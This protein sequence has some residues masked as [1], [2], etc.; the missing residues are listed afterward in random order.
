MNQRKQI[1]AKVIEILTRKKDDQFQTMAE[2]RV[3]SRMIGKGDESECP[4][5]NV[6]LK[7]EDLEKFDE[8]PRT[9]KRTAK[10]LIECVVSKKHDDENL[11]DKADDF[12]TQVETILNEN[13]FLD[14]TV[15][16][17]DEIG[18]EADT[19]Q[20]GEEPI[21]GILLTYDVVYYSNEFVIPDMGDF[22][23]IDQKFQIDENI[24]ESETTLPID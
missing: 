3:H 19:T 12:C 18:I 22:E 1:R 10:L 24:M 13:R 17:T 9:K 15:E 16:D 8:S 6:V 21:A 14:D 2:G 23:T 20:D 7:K 4:Y 11:D 5:I